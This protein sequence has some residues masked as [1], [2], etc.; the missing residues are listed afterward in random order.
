MHRQGAEHFDA[1]TEQDASLH[2]GGDGARQA[3][4]DAVEGPADA[5]QQQDQVG[6]QVGTHGLFQA[7]LR[8]SRDQ[9]RRA[10][11]RPGDYYRHTVAQAEQRTEHGTAHG[12][13]PHPG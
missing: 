9:Q 10:R 13:G 11:D 6:H 3:R 8:Q 5:D 7:E 1:E 4:D 12:H 2:A